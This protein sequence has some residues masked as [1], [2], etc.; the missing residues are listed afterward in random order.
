M[1]LS[2]VVHPAAISVLPR[3]ATFSTVAKPGELSEMTASSEITRLVLDEQRVG[4]QTALRYRPRLSS[5]PI[6]IAPRD[7][8]RLV[9][10]A[11]RLVAQ[12]VRGAEAECRRLLVE[13]HGQA[14]NLIRQAQ[15][16]TEHLLGSVGEAPAPNTV[17]SSTATRPPSAEAPPP[18]PPTVKTGWP[19]SDST[20]GVGAWSGDPTEHGER[21]WDGFASAE[22]DRWA[23]LDEDALVGAHPMRRLLRRPV[24]RQPTPR[25]KAEDEQH[26][27]V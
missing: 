19:Q 9:A 2:S 15:V 12:A 23:F 3:P 8:A 27:H 16:D 14:S 17:A 24:P 4:V 6:P 13:A 26:D 7:Q 1:T 18:C 20:T 21:F 25:P 11:I 5:A 22:E 10:L